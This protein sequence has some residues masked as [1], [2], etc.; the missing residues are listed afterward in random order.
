MVGGYLKN[1]QKLINGP[2]LAFKLTKKDQTVLLFGES[3]SRQDKCGKKEELFTTLFDTM[4]KQKE[5]DNIDIVLEL[6]KDSIVGPGISEGRLPTL[7][8][9]WKETYSHRSYVK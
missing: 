2:M 7:L 3:H 6:G 4:M 8:K 1:K 9:S 5:C